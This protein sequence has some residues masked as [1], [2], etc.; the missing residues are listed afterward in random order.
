LLGWILYDAGELDAATKRF[1]RA[2]NDS[3]PKVR[4]SAN[5]GLEAIKRKRVAP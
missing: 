1:E 3:V 2:A 4:E 5:R